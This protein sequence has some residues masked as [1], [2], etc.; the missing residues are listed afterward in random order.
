MSLARRHRERMLAVAAATVAAIPAEQRPPEGPE[1]TEYELMRA[2]LG[3]DL[4]ALREIQSIEAKIERKAELLPRYDAWVQG[5]LEAAGAEGGRGVQDDVLVQTMIW[6]MDVGD[7][8]GALPLAAYV[9]R[10]GVTLPERF[11][12][13]AGCLIAELAADAAIKAHGQG[14]AFDLDV[15]LQIEELTASED[16]PDEVR[17][18]V[19]K[20]IGHQLAHAADQLEAG[21]NGPAGGK[22]AAIAG[23]LVKLRRALELNPKAG[24]K[25]EIERLEREQ[26]K[27]A[28]ATQGQS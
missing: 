28:E 2:Q 8:T 3:L 9:L 10:W 5:V 6:R 20:A 11:N 13:T 24:V 16:M 12:R 25:K 17:A 7:F 14:Q 22:A 19:N 21:G 18:K 26:R 15:L 23:A 4:A 27:L 1:A